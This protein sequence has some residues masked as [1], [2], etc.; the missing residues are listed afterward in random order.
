MTVLAYDR[1][2]DRGVQ[3][4]VDGV[5]IEGD[6]S[7]PLRPNG[8]VIVANGTGTSRLS[9]RTREIAQHVYDAGFATLLLDI[10]TYDEEKEDSLTG[11]FQ[12]DIPLIASRLLGASH[13]AGETEV[14]TFPLGCLVAGTASAAAIVASVREPGILSA[15]VSHGGRPDLAGIDL[16]KATTPTLL[17]AGSEDNRIFELNRWALRRLR[18]EAKIAVI[19]GGSHLFEEPDALRE[20][21]RLSLRWFESH[22]SSRPSF[23]VE[24]TLFGGSWSAGVPGSAS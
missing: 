6:W 7:V 3:I 16:H 9:R 17:I 18:G 14:G 1:P 11:A 21:S 15:I 13:W 22:L 5:V 4:P 10:L 24:R 8:T 12:L 23:N 19:P 20:M 2:I